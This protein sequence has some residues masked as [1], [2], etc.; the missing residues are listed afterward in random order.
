MEVDRIAN[1]YH[2]SQFTADTY[3]SIQK[4]CQKHNL[5]IKCIL[6]TGNNII[7]YFYDETSGNTTSEVIE[8][9]QLGYK[10]VA[11][12]TNYLSWRSTETEG[13]AKALCLKM[14]SEYEFNVTHDSDYPPNYQVYINSKRCFSSPE[15]RLK[16]TR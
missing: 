12:G 8:Y 6:V 2:D 14:G 9:E 13:F 15:D 4:A 1:E 11:R 3:C 7:V 5:P 16:S 10:M